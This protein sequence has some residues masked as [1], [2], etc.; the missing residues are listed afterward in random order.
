MM[1]P[2]H[3]VVPAQRP[4]LGDRNPALRWAQK[5]QEEGLHDAE[6]QMSTIE[7]YGLATTWPFVTMEDEIDPYEDFISSSFKDMW[8]PPSSAS[9][10]E[11]VSEASDHLVRLGHIINGSVSPA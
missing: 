11:F 9:F 1:E 3:S 5:F 8:E 7:E 4:D 2:V 6:R 10:R